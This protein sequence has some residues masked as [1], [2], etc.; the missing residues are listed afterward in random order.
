MTGNTER[1][2]ATEGQAGCTTIATQLRVYWAEFNQAATTRADLSGIQPGDLNGTYFAETDYSFAHTG[3][4]DYV[5]TAT[6]SLETD[7]SGAPATVIMT[8]VN[9]QATWSGN[10]LD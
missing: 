7:S 4:D 2:M 3:S 8:V 5:I 9:G 10:L 6:S 1:A